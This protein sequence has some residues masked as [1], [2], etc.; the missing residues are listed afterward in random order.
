MY[1][2]L[3]VRKW[4]RWVTFHEIYARLIGMHASLGESSHVLS[5]MR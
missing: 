1:Q 3:L 4:I 5:S 2:S